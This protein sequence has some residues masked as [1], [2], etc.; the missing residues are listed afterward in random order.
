MHKALVLFVL[1]GMFGTFPAHS[2]TTVV[3]EELQMPAWLERG[4][5]RVPL[6]A[7]MSL[8]EFDVVETGQ[9]GKLQLQF[10]DGS[11]LKLGEQ[12]RLSIDRLRPPSGTT[13]TLHAFLDVIEGTFSLSAQPSA[14]LVQ[15]EIGVRISSTIIDVRQAD[16]CGQ[17]RAKAD[18]VCLIAGSVTVRHPGAGRF[19]MDQPRTVFVAP[20]AEEPMPVA[21]ADPEMVSAWS[22]ATDSVAGHGLTVRGGGWIVQLAALQNEQTARVMAQRLRQAGYAADLT[23]AQ[24]KGRTFYRLRIDRFDSQLEARGFAG[25]IKGQFGVTEPWVTQLTTGGVDN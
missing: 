12:A 24:L 23:T 1:I 14:G 16:V 20:K 4:G 21:P 13:G 17:S 18:L 10:C 5:S 22:V 19:I 6:H 9:Q 2:A 11:L 7:G 3:V 15:R 8:Q 25:R